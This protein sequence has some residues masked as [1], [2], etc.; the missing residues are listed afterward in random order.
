MRGCWRSR[1]TEPDVA[2]IH[3]LL[4]GVGFQLRADDPAA[5]KVRSIMYLPDP[6]PNPAARKAA[7]ATASRLSVS[8]F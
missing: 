6:Q 1:F 5:M 3:A 7:A 2:L 8:Q 4:N